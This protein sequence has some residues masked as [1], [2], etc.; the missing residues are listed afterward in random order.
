RSRRCD[1][2]AKHS[3]SS[4]LE[5][6][7]ITKRFGTIVANR[8][9][10]LRVEAGE[11]RG[12]VGENGAGKTTLMAIASGLYRPGAGAVVVAGDA[13]DLRSALDAIPA[14][15]DMVHQHFLLV[16]N[17]TV[18]ENVVLGIR[19]GPL[20]RLRDAERAV[21]EL[22]E[23]YGLPVDPSAEVARLPPSHQQ[24]VEI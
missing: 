14:G 17:L 3:A 6:S 22:A 16:Q 24:R 21:A 1:P 2:T 4:L 11:V 8:D 12:L 20:L 10:S 15:I 23:R 9:V 13:S 19:G 7:G 5:L 18:A